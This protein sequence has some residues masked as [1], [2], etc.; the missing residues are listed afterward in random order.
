[1]KI[2]NQKTLNILNIKYLGFIVYSVRIQVEKELQIVVLCF[3][4]CFTLRPNFLGIV[5]VNYL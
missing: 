4:L 1:M 2:C 3:Y 5:V